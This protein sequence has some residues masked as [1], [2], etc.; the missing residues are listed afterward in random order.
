VSGGEEERT[1]DVLLVGDVIGGEYEE[2]SQSSS[3]LG[4][5]WIEYKTSTRK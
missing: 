3:K 1:K 2:E 4:T 5:A